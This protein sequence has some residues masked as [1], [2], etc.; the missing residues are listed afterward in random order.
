VFDTNQKSEDSKCSDSK[1][2]IPLR[3][4]NLNSNIFNE[5]PPS[6]IKTTKLQKRRSTNDIKISKKKL[7]DE[8]NNTKRKRSLGSPQTSVLKLNFSSKSAFEPVVNS[9][10]TATHTRQFEDSMSLISNIEKI[11]SI[12]HKG[13]ISSGSSMDYKL[14]LSLTSSVWSQSSREETDRLYEKYSVQKPSHPQNHLR[15]I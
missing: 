5:F 9:K 10:T 12:N 8:E 3:T 6:S 15:A 13:E 1:I 14:C 2:R 7:I 4:L 11:L